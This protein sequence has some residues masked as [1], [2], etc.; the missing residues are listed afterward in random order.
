[1]HAD[2]AQK[3][4]MSAV[5]DMASN[6]V[7]AAASKDFDGA[8]T[9]NL[10]VYKFILIPASDDVEEVV[11]AFAENHA[12]GSNTP[13]SVSDAGFFMKQLGGAASPAGFGANKSA[14]AAPG[15]KDEGGKGDEDEDDD[16]EMKNA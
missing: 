3:L 15:K 11:K 8:T 10:P 6:K 4:T 12:A 1:V 7:P 2:L 9:I 5:N 14:D 16:V 13:G